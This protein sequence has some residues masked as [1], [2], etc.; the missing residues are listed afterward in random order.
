MTSP[1]CQ[2]TGTSRQINDS[3]KGHGDG[4]DI[5]RPDTEDATGTIMS[6]PVGN[7][8]H[9]PPRLI[10]VIVMPQNRQ[11]QLV[12]HGYHLTCLPPVSCTMII[13]AEFPE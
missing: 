1:F 3:Q 13:I 2:K 9:T 8:A 10:L 5:A 7:T 4:L 11:T 6:L 12:T